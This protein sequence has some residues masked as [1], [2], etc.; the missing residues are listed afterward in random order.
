M[1]EANTL[2]I[3]ITANVIVISLFCTFQPFS[4]TIFN[5]Q[6]KLRELHFSNDWNEK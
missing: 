6:L 3:K 2:I 1:E 4:G 5:K